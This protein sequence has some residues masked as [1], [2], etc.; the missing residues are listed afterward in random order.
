[1][2]PWLVLGAG[3]L[4]VFG[5]ALIFAVALGRSAARAD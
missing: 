4:A 2:L 3:F 1:V 5:A